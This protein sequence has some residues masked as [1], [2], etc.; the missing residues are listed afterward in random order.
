MDPVEKEYPV[1]RFSGMWSEELGQCI[2]ERAPAHYPMELT[3]AEAALVKKAVNQGIDAHLEACFIQGQD[4][5]EWVPKLP[6]RLGGRLVCKVTPKSLKCLVR[7][8]M[9]WPTLWP[10][11]FV[12]PCKSN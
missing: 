2:L 8:L 7:R 9:I 1:A 12:T 4:S 5:Y 10:A 3:Q 6:G 11:L